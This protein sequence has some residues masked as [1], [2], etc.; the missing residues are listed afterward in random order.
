MAEGA[1]ERH[2]ASEIAQAA[3]GQAPVS[4]APPG[5][6]LAHERLRHALRRFPYGRNYEQ[7][8]RAELEGVGPAAAAAPLHMCGAGPLPLTG[9]WWHVLTG[10]E[11]TLVEIEQ[12]AAEVSQRVLEALAVSGVLDVDMVTVCVADAASVDLGPGHVMAASLLPLDTVL[13]LTERRAA[14][15]HRDGLL[16]IRSAAGLVARLAYERVDV[17]QLTALGAQWVGTVAPASTMGAPPTT[18]PDVGIGPGWPV[19]VT[20]APAGVLN[21]TEVLQA[22]MAPGGKHR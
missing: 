1:M 10:A 17:D 9:I 8:V 11:I 13:R 4:A 22:M 19:P 16:L 21:V 6:D 14:G 7:L 3:T 5:S 15:P 2:Y 12:E 18:R 20:H